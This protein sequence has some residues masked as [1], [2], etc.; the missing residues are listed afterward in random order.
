MV[1]ND[2]SAQTLGTLYG[3]ELPGLVYKDIKGVQTYYSASTKL[4]HQLLRAIAMKAGVH[5]YNDIDDGTFVNKSFVSIHTVRGG[6]RT[7]SFPAPV[8]LY[9][10]YNDKSVVVNNKQVTIEL[11]VRTTALYFIGTE[12]QWKSN[13]KVK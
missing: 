10:V 9:D 3:F 12:L 7:L 1:A 5:I 6:K 4:S 2:K 13:S 8:N 11:P